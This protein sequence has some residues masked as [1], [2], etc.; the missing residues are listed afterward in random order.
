MHRFI[1]DFDLSQE[2]VEITDRDLLH[3]WSRV[4][5][6]QE[7]SEVVLVDG[8]GLE[9]TA[10][11]NELLKSLAKLVIVSRANVSREP[12]RR[13]HLY[14]ALLKRENFELVAQ[15]AVEVGAYALIPLITD[16]TVKLGL[17]TERVQKIMKEAA[18][19]SGRGMV[20]LVVEP[21]SLAQALKQ[22]DTM[23]PGIF[24]DIDAP[25]LTPVPNE[26]VDIFIGPEGG[27]SLQEKEMAAK[28]GLQNASLG[29]TI[30]R[31]ETAAIVATY[32]MA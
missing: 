28:H 2:A 13:V 5:R 9:A 3:Q 29:S 18:E 27:W 4:L 31:A 8:K 6:L 10:V 22:R 12:K 17:K 20:P 26:D 14:Q 19:Q 15:K 16:H 24:F 30:L 21:V 32:R 25:V 1:G 7:G 23:R 11:I